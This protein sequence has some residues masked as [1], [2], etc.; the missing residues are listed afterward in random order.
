MAKKTPDDWFQDIDNALAYRELFGREASW[1]KTELN[2]LNDPKGDTAIGPNLVYG[3]GDALLSTLTVPDPEFVVKAER[4]VGI[5]KAPIV[6]S[7]DNLFIRKLRLKR[8]VD[9]AVMHGYLY[10]TIILKIGYD[11]EFGWAPYYD[12]GQNNNMLGLTFTQFSRKGHRIESPDIQPGWPWVRPVLP[13]DVVFPWGT[14]F[15]EDAPWVAHR[16]VRHIDAIKADPKYINTSNLKAEM[17]MEDFME[18]YLTVGTQKQQQRLRGIAKANVNT[19]YVEL[20]EI[21]DRLR[22]EILVISRNHKKYLRNKPDAI[23]LACGMPFVV[24]TL[25]PHP[26]S[27]WSTPPAYYLGQLQK[28]QFDISL[29]AEKQR[30][31]D[32]LKFIFRDGAI[33]SDAISRLLS[34][35]VGAAEGIK[36]QFPMNEI[37]ATVPRGNLLDYTLQSEQNRRD[38]REA[39][40][41]SR[42]QM[43]EPLGTP[44]RRTT[45]AE[46][47]SAGAGAQTRTNRRQQAVSQLYIEVIDKVNKVVFEYWK[48]PREVMHDEGWANVTGDMLKGDYLYSVSLSTKRNLSRAERK[49]EALMMLGQ[50]A[51]FLQGSD[52]KSLYT[53]LSDAVSDPAFERILAPLTGKTAQP[54]ATPNRPAAAQGGQR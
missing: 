22:G 27:I 26:R 13:H 4:R 54:A 29:Q 36:S 19:E 38:A 50:M 1:K 16:I 34:A 2:Y 3:Q 14:I 31:I 10:G 35:D 30:R 21:R 40:G 24:A 37:I 7:L 12:I 41:I 49:I 53:Y 5:D 33:S 43:G 11:S 48:M 44:G 23:Q 32:I 6:E 20:W 46:V 17:T 28:T 45:K 25:N 8:Y 52:I 47:L 15:A 39:A 51:P 18:S 9:R 42:N